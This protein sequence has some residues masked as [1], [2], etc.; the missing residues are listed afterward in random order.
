MR[1]TLVKPG[2]VSL[3]IRM[4]DAG[5]VMQDLKDISWVPEF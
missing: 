4:Q 3:T 5:C 1:M 2:L